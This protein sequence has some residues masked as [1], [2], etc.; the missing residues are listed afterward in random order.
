MARLTADDWE[1]IR[2][3]RGPASGPEARPDGNDS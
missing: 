3:E 2:A 1:S